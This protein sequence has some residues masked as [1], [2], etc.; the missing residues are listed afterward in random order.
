MLEG[1]GT[2]PSGDPDRRARVG[3]CKLVLMTWVGADPGRRVREGLTV[4]DDPDRRARAGKTT[5]CHV[6]L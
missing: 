5:D 4:F 3:Y 6:R 2:P 1:L